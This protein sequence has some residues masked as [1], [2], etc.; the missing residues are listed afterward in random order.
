MYMY[1]YYSRT[2]VPSIAKGVETIKKQTQ[3]TIAIKLNHHGLE[4]PQW[5]RKQAVRK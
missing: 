4:K 5:L 3:Q 1:N 2:H